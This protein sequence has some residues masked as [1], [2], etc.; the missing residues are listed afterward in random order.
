MGKEIPRRGFPDHL[1]EVENLALAAQAG[2]LSANQQAGNKL[3][4]CSITEDFFHGI[5]TC[6]S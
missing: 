1:D 6:R 5:Y 2:D 3:N 4:A